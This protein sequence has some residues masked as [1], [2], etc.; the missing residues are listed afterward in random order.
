MIRLLT[1]VALKVRNRA[2]C[3]VFLYLACLGID[4]ANLFFLR[5]AQRCARMSSDASSMPN[6]NLRYYSNEMIAWAPQV[7][8][9]V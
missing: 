7:C 4:V 2:R 3:C 6:L 5:P 9:D 1:A 8:C